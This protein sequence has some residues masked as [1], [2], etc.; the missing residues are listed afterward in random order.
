MTGLQERAHELVENISP[1]CPKNYQN[2]FWEEFIITVKSGEVIAWSFNCL[3]C[4]QIKCPLFTNSTKTGFVK[5]KICNY[6]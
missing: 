3:T 5:E 1:I 6:A 4:D 2:L